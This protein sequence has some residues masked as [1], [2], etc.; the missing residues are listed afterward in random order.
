MMLVGALTG[1]FA[2][3]GKNPNA[4]DGTWYGGKSTIQKGV[5]LVA[6]FGKPLVNLA[7]GVQD[8]SNLRFANQ[9]DKDGKATGWYEI[10]DMGIVTKNVKRNTRRLVQALTSVFETLGGGKSKESSWWEGETKFEKGMAIVKM[11]AE[12]YAK[13]G[14]SV[15]NISE[16]VNKYDVTETVAK[17]K[18]FIGVFTGVG[19]GEDTALL[20]YKRLL[21]KS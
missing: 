3:V 10:K 8:M 7:K 1:T 21:F 16:A 5:D 20:N 6:G 17:V 13:L 2:K 4:Q 15:K 14:S 18:Q 9:W 11:I 19:I 12:P